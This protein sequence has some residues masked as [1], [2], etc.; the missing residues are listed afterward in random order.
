[1]EELISF[2][3]IGFFANLIDGCIGMAYGTIVASILTTMGVPALQISAG[4]HFSEIFTTAASALSLLKIKNI[5]F[6]LLKKIVFAGVIGGLSGALCLSFVAQDFIQPFITIYLIIVGSSL[7]RKALNNFKH[8]KRIKWLTSIGFLG[9]FCDALCGGGWGPSVNGSL[10]G[11]SQKVTKTIGTVNSAEFFVTLTQSIVFFSVIG[12]KS[13]NMVGGLILGGVLAAP[14]A[15]YIIQKINPRI[16]CF[17]IGMI[18]FIANIFVF[19]KLIQ[20]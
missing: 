20:N 12:L 2:I 10:I 4:I 11:Q 3:I 9:G 7:M 18:I 15:V 13:L 5:D 1:M 16:L 19:V 14:L 17:L 8:K 6:K